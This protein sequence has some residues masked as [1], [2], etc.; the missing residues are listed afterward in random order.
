M[1]GVNV[2]MGVTGV[3][4]FKQSMKESESAVKALNESLK[5]NESNLK[6]TGDQETYLKNKTQILNEAIKKQTEVVKHSQE[7]L[8][9]MR[10]NGVSETSTA[11]QNMRAKANNALAKLID[12]KT[13]L[14][15]TESG[16]KDAGDAL[17]NI[18]KGVAWDNVAEGIGKINNSLQTAARSAI[19]IGKTI[20]RSAMDSTQWADD[21]LTRS[22]QYG[23]DAETLQRMEN[24]AEYID[25][26]VD[27]IISAKDKLAKNRETLP[28]LLGLT[29]D[30]KSA[31]DLFWETG[32]AIMAL[33]D[34]FDKAEIA[35]KVFG[36]SWRELLPLFTAGREQ[37]EELMETQNVLTNEQV[38]QLG[39][40]DDAIK[41]VQQQIEL[42]KNQFW[43]DNAD[44][45]TELLQWTIDNKDAVV[46]ALGTIAGGF[47][48]LKMGELAAN[49]GKVVNGFKELGWL[50]GGSGSGGGAG[51][52]GSSVAKTAA[53]SGVLKAA[54]AA[55]TGSVGKDL[56][57]GTGVAGGVTLVALAPALLAQNA[58]YAESEA[59]RQRRL[60][61]AGT[62]NSLEAQFL[63]K[64]AEA[65]NI[66]WGENQ[67]YAAVQELLM[68]MKNR[69]G[70]EMS[71]LHNM[72][73][74]STTSQGNYTWNELQRLWNGE[75][76]DTGRLVAT[77]EAVTDAYEQAVQA[78]EP[79]F[80]PDAQEQLQAQADSMTVK[81][82]AQLVYP[83]GEGFANGLP[84]VPYDGFPAILH[85]GERVLTAGQ[86]KN[87]TFNNNTY[88]G[89]VNLN[90]AQDI[91]AL[92][93]SIDRHNRRQSRGYGA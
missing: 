6:L 28:E 27:T 85:R 44:K 37:Y 83:E 55:L 77:L 19:R 71:K 33:D 72:L 86:N 74:G 39:A 17:K 63:A 38:Q 12:M 56:L 30:G 51:G 35:Q 89:G 78:L 57:L 46:A 49:V 42:M 21:I 11:F 92:V 91:D 61:V 67:D 43:A 65:L 79:E 1:A 7:A 47:G 15:N 48:L 58:A 18:G 9:S 73:S 41:N 50:G 69:S 75:A 10:K 81:V 88:F 34:S 52:V 64:A 25:T 14:K 20:A 32:D 16:A 31:E 26:D 36:R 22:T 40:A 66:A 2:K 62:S 93:D 53:K 13:E 5:V 76:L 45:I 60:S 80:A 23:V 70:I 54:K 24:V 59:T 90:N 8:E 3:S 29:T 82:A 87:Y 68:G 84:F 4:Q